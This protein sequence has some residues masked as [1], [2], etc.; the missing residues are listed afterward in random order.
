[1]I[2]GDF[3]SILLILVIT[4]QNRK[5]LFCVFL[6]LRTFPNSNWPEIFWV[7][8]SYHEKRLERKKSTRWALAP[9]MSVWASSLR[10]H[11]SSSPDAQLDLKRLYKDP[12]RW[13]RDKA[14]EKHETEK[15]RLFQ[16]RLEGEMLS[17]SPPVA[18]STSLTRHHRNNHEEVVVH[19]GTMGLW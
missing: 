5:T 4:L 1:M 9:P 2:Y 7:L 15:Q 12:P 10:Y 11:Q 13:S 8:I 17:E 16:R 6:H 3:P 19:L 14:V 18:S